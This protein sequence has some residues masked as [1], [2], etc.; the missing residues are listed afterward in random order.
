MKRISISLV[1]AMSLGAC[2]TFPEGPATPGPTPTA[3]PT[4]ATT[5]S[6]TPPPA[7]ASKFDPNGF[8]T[9]T[10]LVGFPV[11]YEDLA[12]SL[13]SDEL[14]SFGKSKIGEMCPGFDPAK[15]E[16]FWRSFWKALSFAEC[17]WKRTTYYVETTM[18]TDPITGR[19]VAS[20][21]LFQLSYQDEKSYGT[22]VCDFDPE[23]D[24]G[25]AMNDPKKTI[26]EPARNISCAV[27]IMNKQ[28]SWAPNDTLSRFAGRYW[29][30]MRDSQYPKRSSMAAAGFER[31][32][33]KLHELAPFCK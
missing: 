8:I 21:G 12:L 5:P 6:P 3:S 15:K 26:F 20:E 31:F 29:L 32:K 14:W 2:A 22:S 23:K 28:A 17:S 27:K 11:G 7:N 16:Q 18:G 19:Q 13:M 9:E 1:L 25:L 30:V 24:R 33:K 4:P 10:P